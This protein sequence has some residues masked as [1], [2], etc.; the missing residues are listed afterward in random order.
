MG[1][2]VYAV[3]FLLAGMQL[4]AAADLP[5]I[6][7]IA[8]EGNDITQ[9]VT[10]QRELVVAVGDVAEPAMI[11]RSRQAIQDLGLFRKVEVH[12][13]PFEEGVRLVFAVHEKWYVLPIPRLEVNSDGDTG[14]GLALRW[15]NLW[16]LN[17]RLD[18]LAVR[19][20]FKREDK[21][22]ATN[23][24]TNYNIP[25]L[26]ESRNALNFS[27]SYNDQD[28]TS[29]GGVDYRE[30]SERLGVVFSR[31][32]GDGPAS[33]G[34]KAGG[35]LAWQR[36]AT[37]GANAPDSFGMALSPGASL[38]YN[39]L[40]DHLYSETGQRFTTSAGVA[41]NG[42]FS[43]YGY[44]SHF[45]HYDNQI[46]IGGVDHQTLR[47]MAELG[48]YYGGPPSAEHNA[49]EFGGSERLRGYDREIIDGN[50][51]YY[52]SIDYLRPLHWNWL[53]LLTTLEAGSALD[54]FNHPRG[55][56]L[57]SSV[58]VGVT[59]RVTW[60]VNVEFE[61]GVAYPLVAGDGI[62]FFARAL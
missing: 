29:D 51:A 8:F 42:V 26:G 36:Q 28:S 41:A 9:A 62:R 53:R 1:A 13:E 18:L 25:F 37:S 20:D 35:G 22:S 11:E 2:R 34:W 60:L 55:R 52:G 23:F 39:D 12:S 32:L 50:F 19:R 31:S 6:R 61:F 7:A 4:A 30:R 45:T 47:L 27:A 33:Q 59:V 40:H 10:M 38:S 17:H 58:G 44:L 48:G 43:D 14:Y 54:N 15:N 5:L 24:S 56:L 21:D 49:F 46:A 57:Y 3:W 16:G